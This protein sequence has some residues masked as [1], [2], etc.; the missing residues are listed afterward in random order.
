MSQC[1][2]LMALKICSSW[3][4]QFFKLQANGIHL[5]KFETKMN[6]KFPSP[7]IGTNSVSDDARNSRG[8][9][10]T[11]LAYPHS[12]YTIGC[13]NFDDNL[14]D[15]PTVHFK[16]WSYIQIDISVKSM[17]HGSLT[18]RPESDIAHTYSTNCIASRAHRWMESIIQDQKRELTWIASFDQ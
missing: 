7:Y 1:R 11:I 14:K 13:C 9:E 12:L 10:K 3:L 15:I 5:L 6:L 4:L 18:K 8:W 2:E 17:S 16:I